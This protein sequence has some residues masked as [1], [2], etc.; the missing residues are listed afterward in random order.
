MILEKISLLND[1]LPG[2]DKLKKGLKIFILFIFFNNEKKI[3][4][5]ILKN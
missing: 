1:T 2:I 3:Y 4:K 5:T